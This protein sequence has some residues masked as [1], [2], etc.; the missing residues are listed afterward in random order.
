MILAKLFTRS[1]NLLVLDEP[2]N[3]LDVETLEA[4]EDR[5]AEYSGTL[6]V[7]SHDRHFLDAVVTSTLVFEA[8]G[9]IRRHSGGYSDWAPQ[10]RAL[11]VGDEPDAILPAKSAARQLKTAAP[12]KLSYNLQRELDA[13]P[14]LIETLEAEVSA[15]Q[16]E[17][18]AP[19]FYK[20]GH[21]MTQARLAALSAAQQR[22]DA[23]MERWAELERES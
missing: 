1:A 6:I 17:V 21:A 22:L 13:L 20:Q 5:L 4:L 7:V 2:T 19:G 12:Q 9:S 10:H 23:S 15:L 14:E 3:D 18:T 8:D 11:A 16:A